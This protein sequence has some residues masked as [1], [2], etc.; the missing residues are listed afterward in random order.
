MPFIPHTAEEVQT[1]LAA[2][3]APDVESLFSEIPGHLRISGL[4]D[5]ADGLSENELKVM[6]ESKFHQ[7]AKVENYA[8]GGAYEHHI[9]HAV[10]DLVSRGEFLTAYTPYQAEASQ[11]T[12]QI[13]FEFQTMMA[14][15]MGHD[16]SNASLYDGASATAEAA[17]MAVRLM[18]KEDK[19]VIYVPD[20]L[21]PSYR[22]VLESLLTPQKVAIESIPFAV[23]A[24]H[25]TIE[26][27]EKSYQQLKRCT[28]LIIPQPNY[29]G[30]LEEVS[31]LT[32]WVHSKGGL[33]IGVVNPT[34]MALLKPPGQ[35]GEKGVDIACGEGQP[36]GVPMNRGGPYFGFLTCFKKSIRQVP[37][38]II[39]E[40]VDN[41][42]QRGFTL[43]L[44]AR[45]QHIRRAKATSNICTNQGL[46]VTAASIYLS[47]MGPQGLKKVALASHQN[48]LYL[49]KRLESLPGAKLAFNRP[50]FHEVAVHC[51][52]PVQEIMTQ[53]I[54]CGYFPGINIGESYPELD[55]TLLICTTE[56]KTKAQIDTF[57]ETLKDC[58]EKG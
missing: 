28:A 2:I 34:A 1:M 43:T 13:L 6:I 27:L 41:K 40:T 9:P 15:L 50:F 21:H 42:N 29:F 54:S 23:S 33:A 18:R 45:E 47:L 20:S 51:P 10:W 35:W 24:G 49:A 39:G 11:G 56:T 17:L 37:G 53:M 31:M 16:V 8:G 25:T 14:S 38:R 44:Q 3:G 26:A 36:L 4:S 58:W 52:K 5:I 19:P 22:T 46:L 57:V 32:D 30:V 12:L 48:A 55:H 7:D